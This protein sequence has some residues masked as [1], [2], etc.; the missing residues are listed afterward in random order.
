VKQLQGDQPCPCGRLDVEGRVLSYEQC[1]RPF[2]ESDQNASDAVSLM[3]SRYTAFVLERGPY[4]L[5]T[6]HAAHRPANVDFDLQAKWLGLEVRAYRPRGDEH[7]EVEFVAR[8]RVAGR[9]V[10]LHELSRF[11]KVDGRW[12]YL[13]GKHEI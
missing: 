5:S 4:L 3:R 1:C 10:R 9:A 13:G 8:N 6:W 12:Y 11:L 7:A 2:L